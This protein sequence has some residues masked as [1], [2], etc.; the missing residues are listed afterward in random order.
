MEELAPHTGAPTE[1]WEDST[2][3]IYV[4]EDERVT[5]RVKHINIPV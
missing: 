4:F 5:P 1:H 3:Y 2:N